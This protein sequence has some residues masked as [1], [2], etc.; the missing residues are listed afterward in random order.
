[1]ASK[2]HKVSIIAKYSEYRNNEIRQNSICISLF[3]NV[4]RKDK[5]NV[6]CSYNKNFIFVLIMAGKLN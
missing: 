2:V 3:D 6:L 1:M 4:I 5:S